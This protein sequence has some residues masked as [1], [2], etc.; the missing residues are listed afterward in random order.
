MNSLPE[1]STVPFSVF[2]QN[3]KGKQAKVELASSN[4][5]HRELLGHGVR[6]RNTT[7]TSLRVDVAGEPCEI[8]QREKTEGS[9]ARASRRV[10][11]SLFPSE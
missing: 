7:S 1:D 8:M 3:K 5:P 10:A 2:I 6:S 4:P 11:R 9:L